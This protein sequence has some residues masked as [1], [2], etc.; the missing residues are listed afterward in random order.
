MKCFKWFKKQK[1]LAK[2]HKGNKEFGDQLYLLRNFDWDEETKH[3]FK[4][5]F[6]CEI[7][8]YNRINKL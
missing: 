7:K 3:W 6:L 8:C 2:Y 1:L 5:Q 4:H